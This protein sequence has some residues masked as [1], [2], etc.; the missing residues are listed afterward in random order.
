VEAD[1]LPYHPPQQLEEFLLEVRERRRTAGERRFLL[2]GSATHPP[3]AR[4]LERQL[5]TLLEIPGTAGFTFDVA[6]FGTERLALD[7]A[8]S[9]V[10]LH[11]SVSQRDLGE[12]MARAS[13]AIVEQRPSV[14]ALTKIPELLLAGV[15]VIA[16]VDA[17]RNTW[18]LAGVSHY[19]SHEQLRALLEGPMPL[20]PVPARDAAAEERF[21][22]VLGEIASRRA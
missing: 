20:P 15:P 2:L 22:R 4:S 10:V 1:Y 5:S 6:G 19:D 14:G 18:S 8:A 7:G 17:S 12:L 9:N 3:T 21:R 13:A 11:G 16:N